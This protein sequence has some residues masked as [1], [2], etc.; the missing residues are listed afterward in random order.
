MCILFIGISEQTYIVNDI[1]SLSTDCLTKDLAKYL[2]RRMGLVKRKDNT[3]VK[4]DVEKFKKLFHQDIKN[5]IVM[6][7]VPAELVINWDQN[8]NLNYFSVPVFEQK[9]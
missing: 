5:V 4:V 2:F 6:D 3:K 8:L 1:L 9:G 7:E